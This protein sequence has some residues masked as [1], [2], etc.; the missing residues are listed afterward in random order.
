MSGLPT[1]CPALPRPIPT[2][3]LHTDGLPT[4]TALPLHTALPTPT[5]LPHTLC[6]KMDCPEDAAAYIHRV[7]R[8]ARW[9]GTEGERMGGMGWLADTAVFC[10]LIIFLFL[11]DRYH[12]L[13]HARAPIKQI[14]IWRVAD[15]DPDLDPLLT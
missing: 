7:G 15:L 9:G 13:F 14:R 11:P 10:A 4:P 8:T 12:S 1:Q 2:H 5:A 6:S 3:P